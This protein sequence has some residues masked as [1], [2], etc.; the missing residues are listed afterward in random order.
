MRMLLISCVAMAMGAAA[1]SVET[2]VSVDTVPD[3]WFI[4]PEVW[5]NPMENWRI[6]EGRIV[7]T[8][9]PGGPT[10]TLQHLT[11]TLGDQAEPA[12]LSVTVQR[13]EAGGAAGSAGFLVGIRMDDPIDDYRSRLLFGEGLYA[14]INTAGEL[15][16]GDERKASRSDTDLGTKPVDLVLRLS[17]DT[18]AT[19]TLELA[20]LDTATGKQRQRLKKSGIPAGRLVGNVAL[21]VN[22][23]RSVA[24]CARDALWAFRDWQL[25][26]EKLVHQPEHAFGPILW[27][28]Y[29]VSNNILKLTAQMAPTGE[30]DAREVA[31]EF[32]DGDAWVEKARAEIQPLSWTAHFRVEDWDDTV[33]IPYRLTW[34]QRHTGGAE[35]AHHW[36]GT[37]RKNPEAKPVVRAGVFSCFM[38]YLFPNRCVAENVA[39]QDPDLL[40]FT[41]DQ[42]Y[43]NVGGWG[44]LRTGPVD[45]MCVN[46][47]RKLALWGWSFRSLMK[48]RPTIT[49]PDDHDV[50]QG[51]IWGAG[52]RKIPL[53]IWQAPS[54]YGNSK[55]VGSVGGYVQ[56]AEFVK[57]VER[58]Q[59]AHLPDPATKKTFAQG[60]S[61]Y[62][63]AMNYGGI[64][65]A[66][67]EDR[68]FKT[69]PQEIEHKHAGPRPDHISEPG[70]A[71]EVDDPNAKLLGDEQ[72]AF[73]RQWVAD[74]RGQKM[75]VAVSQT[76]YCG[77]ATHHGTSGNFLLGDMDSG[78]WPQAGRDKAVD[79]LRRGGV[80]LL[81]GDQH[82]PTLVR[83]GIENPGDGIVSFVTPAGATGYQRWWLPEDTGI[84][85]IA[86]GRHDDRPNTGLYRDGFGNIID[87][88]AVGN[89]PL[90]HSSATTREERGKMKSAGW[91]LVAMDKANNAI[92]VEAWRVAPGLN[93]DEAGDE[94][95]FP[96][97]PMTFGPWEN[98]GITAPKLPAVVL[99]AEMPEQAPEPIVR[100]LDADG[101]CVSAGRMHGGRFTPTVYAPAAYTVEV[102]SPLDDTSVIERFAGVEPGMEG[103]LQATADRR[104]VP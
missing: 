13:R 92:R 60:I 24:G 65:I 64:G 88:L 12:T 32:K 20:A 79:A 91:G 4:T 97:W 25:T 85:R 67:L 69:G 40:M 53:A 29:T 8:H 50:Y 16:I 34:V 47:L 51:N 59:V 90:E 10:M 75:K 36:Q 19:F 41:G 18:G 1:F 81:A 52:G 55:N 82:L 73:L 31:L 45:R 42:L 100:V 23:P 95:Q 80:M 101:N 11:C 76:V 63:T 61:A 49:M 84:E 38:D 83:H 93:V 15:F 72:L 56:P 86:G 98:Y 28:Q 89:P 104:A 9:A 58:T 103:T 74:W 66:I 54:G 102:L 99:D 17:P 2:V 70:M 30:N 94:D 7:T 46:Y 22:A 5:S 39:R 3:R 77:V 96:G 87:V 6:E 68:K 33:D 21:F 57:A 14:G 35:A 26:G 37:I 43:E 27:S 48:D 62:Y 44:I 71:E 78:G